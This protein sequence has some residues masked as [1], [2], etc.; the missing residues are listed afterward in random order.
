MYTIFSYEFKLIQVQAQ[1][2]LF[3]DQLRK[4]VKKNMFNSSQK[5]TH[6]T[7]F[8]ASYPDLR[9]NW[10]TES[11]SFDKLEWISYRSKPP[12]TGPLYRGVSKNNGTPKFIHSI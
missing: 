9:E 1:T 8:T 3:S 5:K 12:E 11:S 2:A 10:T 4:Q 6:L 7:R